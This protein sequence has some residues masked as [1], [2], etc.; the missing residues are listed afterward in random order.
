MKLGVIKKKTYFIYTLIVLAQLVVLLYWANAK[1]NFFIDEL[2]SMG[3]ASNF[4]GKGDTARYITTGPEWKLNEWVNNAEYKK[5]LLVSDEEQLFRLPLHMA[6]KKMLTKTNYEGFLNIAESVTGYDVITARPGILL[7]I[8][9]FIVTEI[10]LI[11]LMQRLKMTTGL[12]YLALAM[13]GF[14]SY[15]I[16]LVMYIR[17]YMLIVMYL[18]AMLNLFY[19]VWND[20]RLQRLLPMEIGILA[21]AYLSYKNSE[22]AVIYFGAISISFVIALLLT[23]KWK[24]FISYMAFG[25]CGLI[26]IAVKTNYIDI[27]LHPADYAVGNNVSVDISLRISEAL[28]G[29]I[30][31][32]INGYTKWM[33]QLF[34]DYYFGSYA[35]FLLASMALTVY[36][37]C[38]FSS[39]N[40][41]ETDLHLNTG[42]LKPITLIAVASWFGLFKISAYVNKGEFVSCFVLFILVLYAVLEMLGIRITFRKIRFSHEAGFACILLGAALIYTIVAA[43]AGFTTW[44]YYCFG[45]VTIIIIFWYGLNQII[46]RLT[47]T[48]MER[49]WYYILAFFVMISALV[50]F[51]TRSIEYIYEDDEELKSRIYYY[52]DMD[53]VIFPYV[54]EIYGITTHEIYDC[55]NQMSEDADIYAVDF[56]QYSYD[57]VDFPETFVLWSHEARDISIVINDLVEHGYEVESL[58]T[59]HVSQAYV[60]RMK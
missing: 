32:T 48:K 52:K 42:K 14:S 43:L 7:N 34:S 10:L 29:E 11:M 2:Y 16:S 6:V 8:L 13:F 57:A 17:F 59:N 60:C 49:G 56:G 9:F 44:R 18:L 54:N 21:L 15:V 46:K 28:G 30:V 47:L 55:V 35:I 23:K 51:K 37:L 25:I 31:D 41:E 45:F 27:L 19:M 20:E 40:T 50:P 39:S 33:I 58:G 4:T 3:Y 1:T 12:Q 53:T 5:Y 38:K 22:L 24:Q 26:Y 36:S